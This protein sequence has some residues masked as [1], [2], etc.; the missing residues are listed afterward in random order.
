MLHI[1]ILLAFT[2]T[3]SI[4]RIISLNKITLVSTEVRGGVYLCPWDSPAE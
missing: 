1:T 2:K 4:K 3:S